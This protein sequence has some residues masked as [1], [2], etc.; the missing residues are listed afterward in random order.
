MSL[1]LKILAALHLVKLVWLK[2]YD[3]DVSLGIKRKDGFNSYCYVHPFV[4][5]GYVK[6]N[7]D[8]TTEGSSYIDEWKPYK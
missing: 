4:G 8:G 7:D 2:H 5:V 3:D 6:L 1:F